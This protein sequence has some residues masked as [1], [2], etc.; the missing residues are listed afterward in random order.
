L[1]FAHADMDHNIPF[2]ASHIS[3]RQESLTVPSL[4]IT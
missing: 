3:G 4:F 2:Y 1:H